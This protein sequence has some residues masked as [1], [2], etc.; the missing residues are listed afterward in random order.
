MTASPNAGRKAYSLGAYSARQL[1][2]LVD[3]AGIK[4]TGLTIEGS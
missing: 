1:G 3:P 4:Q 2:P